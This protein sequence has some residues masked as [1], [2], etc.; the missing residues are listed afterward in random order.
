MCR[1]KQLFQQSHTFKVGS[2]AWFV[3]RCKRHRLWVRVLA[4]AG[5]VVFSS[6]ISAHGDPFSLVL[7]RAVHLPCSPSPH[8][9]DS[10]AILAVRAVINRSRRVHH[11]GH[12]GA[13]TPQTSALP[14]LRDKAVSVN[15]NKECEKNQG[16]GKHAWSR[17][18][19]AE[20]NNLDGQE[21]RGILT[22]GSLRLYPRQLNVGLRV[23][24]QMLSRIFDGNV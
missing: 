11:S 8:H 2:A 1:A 4:L 3:R 16:A 9:T 23:N 12:N 6:R 24:S 7:K 21:A 20:A 10:A 5:V 17:E 19:H 13:L 14:R 15:R 22:R 18:A